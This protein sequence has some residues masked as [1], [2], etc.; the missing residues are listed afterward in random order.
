MKNIH[1]KILIFIISSIGLFSCQ[2]FDE[3]TILQLTYD[4]IPDN[5]SKLHIAVLNDEEV[6]ATKVY[7]REEANK[8]RSIEIYT[9]PG[10]NRT[11]V[12][13]AEDNQGYALHYASDTVD[14]G[15]DAKAVVKL[16]MHL[17]EWSTSPS[18]FQNQFTYMNGSGGDYWDS[19]GIK[20]TKY[21]I[22]NSAETV[23]YY[24]GYNSLANLP[25]DY[26]MHFYVEFYPSRLRTSFAIIN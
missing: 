4:P 7:N 12:V 10:K 24:E 20:N 19:T 18:A 15:A 9:T 8:Q 26:T 23:T 3:E 21:I 1:L 25:W 6:L 5:I 16:N 2:V 13:V 22:M 17:A 11:I 14:I